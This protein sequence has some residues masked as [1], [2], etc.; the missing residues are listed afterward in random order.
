MRT[1]KI[2]SFDAKDTLMRQQLKKLISRL[3]VISLYGLGQSIS[4]FG[5]LVFSYLIIKYHSIELWGSF[6]QIAIWVYLILVFL[7]FGN[8][9]YLLKKFS[10][11][12]SNIFQ[13]WFTHLFSRVILLLPCIIILIFSPLF[14]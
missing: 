12:P 7:S 2:A 13:S 3:K 10:L 6:T 4:P 9:D 14:R 5:K 11:N 1:Q 8:N